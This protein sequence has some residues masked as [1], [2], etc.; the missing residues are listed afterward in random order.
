MQQH[1]M[2]KTTDA[3]PVSAPSPSPSRPTL[4]NLP[5]DII[6][7][8]LSHLSLTSLSHLSSTSHNFNSIVQQ[9]GW[10]SLLVTGQLYCRNVTRSLGAQP[11]VSAGEGAGRGW[12]ALV[13]RLVRVDRSWD[14]LGNV[15]VRYI[16]PSPAVKGKGRGSRGRG[17]LSITFR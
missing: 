8:I 15:G 12:G 11:S 13:K 9:H 5:S 10:R 16:Y 2:G 14:D 6:L 7:S 17:S 3:H 1:L 4:S